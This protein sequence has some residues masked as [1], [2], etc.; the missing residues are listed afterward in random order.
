MTDA[1]RIKAVTEA[2]KDGTPVLLCVDGSAVIG[3][4]TIEPTVRLR[5]DCEV[6]GWMIHECEDGWTPLPPMPREE[7]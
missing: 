4:W 7:R 5:D 2:P 1:A 6:T 3:R